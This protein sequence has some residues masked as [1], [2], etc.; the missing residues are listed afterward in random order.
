MGARAP[1]GALA[2]GVAA[3]AGGCGGAGS[4]RQAVD[5]YI[6]KVNAITAAQQRDQLNAQRALNAFSSTTPREQAALR[7]AQA[8]SAA[9]VRRVEPLDPPPAARAVQ[10]RLVDLLTANRDATTAA[11]DLNAFLATQRLPQERLHAAEVRL[12]TVMRTARAPAAQRRAFATFAADI[13]ALQPQFAA[14]AARGAAVAW[15]AAELERLARLRLAA[16]DVAGSLARHDAAGMR[17]ALAH[18]QAEIRGTDA[19]VAERHAVLVYDRL[20]RRVGRAELAL[21]TERTRLRN[22]FA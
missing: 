21:S 9:L 16:G 10:R 11:A 17:T 8:W 20:V 1:V 12:A 14:L 4:Q 13:G 5:R 2:L 22:R 6:D 15:R 18:V 19:V 3:L 7:R